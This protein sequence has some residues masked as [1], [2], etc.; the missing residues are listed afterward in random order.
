[1]SF[2]TK[3]FGII[4]EVLAFV[5]GGVERKSGCLGHRRRCIRY[6]RS[7]GRRDT[8]VAG[9]EMGSQLE[10]AV[11]CDFAKQQPCAAVAKDDLIE[12]I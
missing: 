11:V 8:A 7:G 4:L 6:C 3:E 5:G 12:A 10:N 9:I 2:G 1:M